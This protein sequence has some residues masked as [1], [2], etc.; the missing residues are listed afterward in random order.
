MRICFA[1]EIVDECLLRGLWNIGGD[2][3]FLW[4]FVEI[5]D[6]WLYLDVGADVPALVVSDRFHLR[7]MLNKFVKVWKYD[8]VGVWNLIDCV[9][10]EGKDLS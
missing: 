2:D 6:S 3:E 4:Q 10:V 5:V 8:M 9:K 7:L 1:L